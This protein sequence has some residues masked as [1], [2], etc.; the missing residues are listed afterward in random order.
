MHTLAEVHSR[1]LAPEQAVQT[2]PT[3]TEWVEGQLLTQR[4]LYSTK[5]PTQVV[6]FVKLTQVE[7]SVGQA[8]QAP[9]KL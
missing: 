5:L 3:T 6:Q 1:Q 4:L 7:Q 9:F 2:V 8:S